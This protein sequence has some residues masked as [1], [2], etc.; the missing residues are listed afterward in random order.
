MIENRIRRGFLQIQQLLLGQREDVRGDFG[1]GL[2]E[3]AKLRGDTAAVT[4]L[5]ERLGQTWA[6]DPALL[7]LNRL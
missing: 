5:Q 1:F 4:A 2:L 7:D 3:A 6:G